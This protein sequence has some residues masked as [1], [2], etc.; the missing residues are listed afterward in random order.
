MFKITVSGN[1]QC[2]KNGNEVG[3]AFQVH[4]ENKLVADIIVLISSE[5]HVHEPQ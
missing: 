5:A 3:F 2:L 1:L 4:A